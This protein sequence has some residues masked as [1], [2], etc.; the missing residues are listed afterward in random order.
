MSILYV[1]ILNAYHMYTFLHPLSLPIYENANVFSFSGI[2]ANIVVVP[3]WA[4]RYKDIFR[5]GCR[6]NAIY[7]IAN[8]VSKQCLHSLRCDISLV[9]VYLPKL[10]ASIGLERSQTKTSLNAASAFL[11]SWLVWPVRYLIHIHGIDT[12][13]EHIGVAGEAVF[14]HCSMQL[15]ECTGLITNNTKQLGGGTELVSC[16]DFHVLI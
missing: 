5:E 10:R 4:W 13:Y 9:S 11:S 1:F 14:L 3:L 6:W 16:Y 7:C 15:L 2:L 12:D 8:N